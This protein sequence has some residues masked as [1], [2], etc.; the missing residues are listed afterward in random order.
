MAAIRAMIAE[1][2][3][4]VRL[5]SDLSEPG[6]HEVGRDEHSGKTQQHQQVELHEPDSAENWINVALTI[7]EGGRLKACGGPITA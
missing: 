5:T 3:Y 6:G 1:T 2:M 4:P 7:P